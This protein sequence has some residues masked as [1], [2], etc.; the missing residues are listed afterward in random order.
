M[1]ASILAL[2]VRSQAFS[3]TGLLNLFL[4]RLVFSIDPW[5]HMRFPHCG[6]FYKNL[7]WLLD[8][9][10]KVSRIYTSRFIRGCL[11]GINAPQCRKLMGVNGVCKS[12][13]ISCFPTKQPFPRTAEWWVCMVIYGKAGFERHIQDKFVKDLFIV[14]SHLVMRICQKSTNTDG[15][16]KIQ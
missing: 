3:L 12:G 6:A 2:C 16:S 10:T 14:I 9:S 11:V 7:F 4:T 5:T 1:T 13:F 15:P 8:R